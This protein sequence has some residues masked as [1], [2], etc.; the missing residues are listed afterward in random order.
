MTWPTLHSQWLERARGQMST[1]PDPCPV[2]TTD[3]FCFICHHSFANFKEKSSC[4]SFFK[5]WPC[6]TLSLC[7]PQAGSA[8][9]CLPSAGTRASLGHGP[10]LHLT[11]I[12]ISCL[13]PETE[14]L[15]PCLGE[16]RLEERE[17]P[18]DTAPQAQGREG[19]P[20]RC[21]VSPRRPNLR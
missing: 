11:F 8:E 21:P 9:S 2:G 16:K 17:T 14:S 10:A 20:A 13:A 19:Q 7:F 5:I 1:I 12:C 4:P 15:H 3:K 18:P 6:R